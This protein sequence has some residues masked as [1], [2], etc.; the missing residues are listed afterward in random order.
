MRFERTV[1]IAAPPAVVFALLDDPASLSRWMPDIVETRLKSGEG[2][3]VVGTRFTQSIREGRRIKAYD[4][5]VTAYEPGRRLAIR[6]SDPAFAV[7]VDYRVGAAGAGTRLDYAAEV[8]LAS[9]WARLMAPLGRWMMGRIL[10]RHL[11]RLRE[12]AEAD[13]GR[14]TTAPPAGT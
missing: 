9:R 14:A 2:L 1:D 4:G 5:V 8:A 10:D 6:L 13:A 7:D 3:A 11:A 12:V